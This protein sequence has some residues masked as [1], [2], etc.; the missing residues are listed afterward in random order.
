M[1]EEKAKGEEGHLGG[2]IESKRHSWSVRMNSLSYFQR[3]ESQHRNYATPRSALRTSEVV[4]R[5]NHKF[6]HKFK[7]VCDHTNLGVPVKAFFFGVP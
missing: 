3:A 1:N 5:F 2:E 4:C 6:K 7:Q